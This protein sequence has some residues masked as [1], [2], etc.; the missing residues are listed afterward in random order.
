VTFPPGV[1]AAAEA[2][3]GCL[4][5]GTADAVVVVCNA[6]Q[7]RI[8]D[9]LAEAARPLARSVDVLVFPEGSRHGEDPPAD[10]AAAMAGADVVFA[11]TSYS[12]SHTQARLAA[13]AHGVRVATLPIVTEAVFARAVAVD[14]PALRRT[15]EAVAARLSAARTARITA[16]A[17]TDIVLE[18]EGRLAISDDGRLDRPG[19]FGNLPAGEGFIAPIETV[20]DGTIVFDGSLPGPGLLATPVRVTVESGRVVDADTAA[21][22]W[23][24]ETLDAGGAHGR[25]I[26][27]LGVGTNPA[28]IVTGNV[29]EDEKVLGTIHLAFGASAGLG[30]ANEARVHIDGVVREPTVELDG[31]R[32]LDAGRLLVSAD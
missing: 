27:E 28:A 5:V 11:P 23:L 9:A 14:Y 2:A 30:G 4:G 22:A 8:A 7:R 16:P 20:G 21:G 24:L 18:L 15:S 25:S 26:A 31:E 13:T 19:A 17:G 10:V 3:V 6:A 29:L 32:L 12:L 1:L